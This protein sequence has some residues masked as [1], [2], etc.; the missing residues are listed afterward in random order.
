MFGSTAKHNKL[1]IGHKAC[2]PLNPDYHRGCNGIHHMGKYLWESTFGPQ[3]SY[4]ST[5]YDVWLSEG[6]P[7]FDDDELNAI[8]DY[9]I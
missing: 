3:K 2:I 5:E 8:L 6:N 4:F 7:K 1:L 9:S